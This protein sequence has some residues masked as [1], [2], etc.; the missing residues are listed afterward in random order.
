[1][2]VRSSSPSWRKSSVTFFTVLAHIVILAGV[3]IAPIVASDTLP[4]VARVIEYFEPDHVMP[5]LPPPAPR[6]AQPQAAAPA[7]NPDANTS[8]IVDQRPS[9]LAPDGISPEP[10]G[11]G[12]SGGVGNPKMGIEGGFGVEG[13]LAP[14][15]TP[16]PPPQ[17]IRVFEGFNMPVK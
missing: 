6:A 17:P 1:V 5:V 14:L 7:P 13:F 16:T 12:T 11:G 10:P 9:V 8:S 2:T 15:P 3:L 4:T